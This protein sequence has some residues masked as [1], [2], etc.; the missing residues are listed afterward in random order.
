MEPQEQQKKQFPADNNLDANQQRITGIWEN[1]MAFLNDLL[2][3]RA[4]SDR[5]ETIEAVR[6]DISFQGHN[7]WI[8]IFSVFVASVGLNDRSDVDLST[9]GTYSRH[10]IRYCD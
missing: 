3:I 4:D 1:I 2:D 7:A 6:K 8:L 9:F 10:G 5:D